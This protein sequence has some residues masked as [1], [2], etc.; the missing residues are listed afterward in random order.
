LKCLQLT[1]ASL[2]VEEAGTVE[3]KERE[4]GREEKL[5]V[6]HML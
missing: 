1:S 6:G 2:V 4:R 3:I 5:S